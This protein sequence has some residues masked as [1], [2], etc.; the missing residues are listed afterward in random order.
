MAKRPHVVIVG[1]GFGGLAATRALRHVDVDVTIVDRNNYHL[2]QPLLYQVASGLLDPSAIASPVRTIVRR[3]PNV[4]VLRAEVTS[5]DLNTRQ[6]TTS[7]GPLDY[8]YL[9]M[10][11]GSVTDYF[12]NQHALM[13][14]IGLKDMSEALALRSRLLSCFER[15]SLTTDAAARRRLL[16][17]A[18]VGAGPT[19][20]EYS[21][22]VAEL[23]KHVLPKDYRRVDFSEVSVVLVEA[24]E[25]VLATFAPRLSRLA[26][27][28]LERKGV[29]IILGQSVRGVDDRGLVLDSGERIETS[30]V[31][32]TAGVRATTPL[33]F[34]ADARG[35]SGRVQVTESLHL[36]GHPEVFVIG[37]AAAVE[38]A[39]AVLPMLAPVAIQG[40][41][42][43]GGVIAARLKG[44]ASSPF[45]YRDKGTMATVGR[46][47]AVAQIGPVH[48]NGLVGWFIWI[49]IHLLYLV[50]F[51]NRALALWSW[52]WNYF[53]WDRPVRLIIAPSAD[54][55]TPEKARDGPPPT[56]D[57]AS[58]I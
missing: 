51:R 1:A 18:I 36:A 26:S 17:F 54:A 45:H 22:A 11:T 44:T 10:A 7:V 25:R 24:G 14:S 5:V 34:V 2:F 31:V 52:A 3:S 42:Y 55:E 6:V 57:V 39:G 27:R 23:I 37:D 58:G 40:G 46:G 12:G 33:E 47:A 4:D 50:G 56:S 21:G 53:F 15:A 32:W 16:T 8:D 13:H 38:Q 30:N 49:F 41:K 19:G 28:S 35:R 9:I 43:V 48:I 20:V 29:R